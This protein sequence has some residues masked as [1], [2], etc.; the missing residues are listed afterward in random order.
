MSAILQD[1]SFTLIQGNPEVPVTHLSYDSRE[2]QPGTLFFAIPGIHTDGHGYIDKAILGGAGSIVMSKPPNESILDLAKKNA[3]TLVLVSDSRLALAWAAR[4]WYEKPDAKLALIGVTGTD[5]KSSTVWYIQQLLTLLNF[6]SGFISTVSMQTGSETRDNSLR[7]ST[8]EAPQIFSLLHSM[9]QGEKT[10]G[11]I[12][13]TSHGLSNKTGRLAAISFQTGVFT[14]IS[15]EHLEFHGSFEQYLSDK[16]NLFRKFKPGSHGEMPVGVI[17]GQSPHAYYLTNA[18]IESGSNPLLYYYGVEG[19]I[20][21]ENANLPLYLLAKDIELQADGSQF[22]LILKPNS[23]ETTEYSVRASI[24]GSFTVE[25][26]MAAVLGVHGL[27]GLEVSQILPFVPQIMGVKGR[28]RLVQ[29]GQPFTVIVD[30]AH[31]PGSFEIVFP[32][33]KQGTRGR[34]IGVFGSAGE[35]D[36]EKRTI[37]GKIA[38]NFSDVL[39]ITNEDPR[40]EDPQIIIDQIIQ[41]IQNTACRVYSIIDRRQ[42]IRQALELAEPGDTV[43]LLGKGHEQSI[44]L[45]S[46]KIPWDEETVAYEE[47]KAMGFPGSLHEDSN[48]TQA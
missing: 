44:I 27:T 34:L 33:F 47:L 35:R 12:E 25:N 1:T 38:G 31:T 42:A 26:I 46:G 5:G 32:M 45:N 22:T 6:R 8:P 41:G 36:V 14:N 19:K 13:S 18:A 24:P 9:V 40:L 17:N 48:N 39:I 4:Q 37:Q 15:H 29:A 2:I 7:Q 21:Q 23:N 10:H 43:V 30:Y 3:A 20:P 11:V 28:M 16:A